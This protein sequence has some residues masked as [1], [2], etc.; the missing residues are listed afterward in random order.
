M[1]RW[2]TISVI[3]SVIIFAC[4]SSTEIFSIDLPE[5]TEI[6]IPN[7]ESPLETFTSVTPHSVEEGES[8]ETKIG[9]S[10]PIE[11]YK[12]L[13]A[14]DYISLQDTLVELYEKVS[15]GV[16]AI[17][18][19]SPMEGSLGS[20]FV[21]DKDGYIVTNFHVIENQA[22][23]E[24]A[25][26]SGN[27]Y[28][29]SIVSM[30]QD[31]DLAVVKVDVPDD[32]LYPLSLGSTSQT[33]VGQMVVAIGN[34][35]GLERTMTIGIVSGKGRTIR[36][37]RTGASGS[38]FTSGDIIQTDAAVNPGNSGGPLLNLNGEVIGV[39]E[40]ILTSGYE[41]VNSSIAFAISVDTIK[42]I[43]PDLIAKG[44]FDYPY[45]GI[46]SL[47]EITLLAQEA[48]GL[49]RSTG[50]YVTDV[51]SGSPAERAGIQA[52]SINTNLPGVS[53]GGDLIIAADGYEVFDFN[54]LIV[55]VT[56]NKRPGDKII[57]TLLRGDEQLDLELIL[58]KREK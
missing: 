44:K 17:R 36:S 9:P 8:T 11:P 51:A 42:R 39:N 15:P 23:L 22:D 57:V 2:I 6:I 38:V 55:Y 27:K 35:F 26:A 56:M 46:F 28:R 7:T 24:V 40:S 21:Y 5:A 34:P 18:T 19:L 48:L 43:V 31:S 33:K 54:D 52:G 30:D 41:S 50:V 10:T 4:R 58:G 45:L 47:G 53:A 13:P 37:Q 14:F 3:L 16:V 29:G 20:G 32:E 49:P 25:F 1:R 12:I